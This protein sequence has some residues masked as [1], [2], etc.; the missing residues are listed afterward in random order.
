MDTVTILDGEQVV[1]ENVPAFFSTPTTTAPRA[2][3]TLSLRVILEVGKVF[4]LK[5]PDGKMGRIIIKSAA[6]H[7]T[8][9]V[10]SGP[11]K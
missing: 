4:T 2:G 9:F 7:G 1:A 8:G 5:G 6:S 11:Y 3:G 10:F